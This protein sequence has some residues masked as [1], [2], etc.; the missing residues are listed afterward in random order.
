MFWS[1]SAAVMKP[2]R[3]TVTDGVGLHVNVAFQTSM[4]VV[5][6]PGAVVVVGDDRLRRVRRRRSVAV[7]VGRQDP[8]QRRVES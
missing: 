3:V 7:R 4:P 2:S 1:K 5:R 8:R 6:E